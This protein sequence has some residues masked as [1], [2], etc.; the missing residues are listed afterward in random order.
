MLAGRMKNRNFKGDTAK[1]D[2]HK[3]DGFQKED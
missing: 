1:V 2:R 3:I